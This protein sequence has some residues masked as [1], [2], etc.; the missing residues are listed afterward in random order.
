MIAYVFQTSPETFTFQL[1]SLLFINKTLR[2]NNLKTR[3][4]MN[5]KISVS[6]ICVEM[7]IY[8]LLYD[9]HDSTFKYFHYLS[10]PYSLGQNF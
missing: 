3:I 2:P 9:L 8:L 7:I 10:F 4:A 1:L 6:I 5:G